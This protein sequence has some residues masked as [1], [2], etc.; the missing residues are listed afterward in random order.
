ML[1]I[2]EMDRFH[3]VF[4]VDPRRFDGMSHAELTQIIDALDGQIDATDDQYDREI[5]CAVQRYALVILDTLAADVDSENGRPVV[6]LTGCD[7]N[8]F[9]VMAK[10]KLALAD[11]DWEHGTTTATAFVNRAFAAQSH[12]EV[13]RIAIE[14]VDVR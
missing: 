14:F 3:E 5:L 8:V 1:A 6:R 13:L 4:G 7:G 2:D 10:V 11:A 12:G 9:V